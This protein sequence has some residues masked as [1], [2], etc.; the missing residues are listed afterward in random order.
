MSGHRSLL[1]AN[2]CADDAEHLVRLVKLVPDEL[3]D[4]VSWAPVVGIAYAGLMPT[5]R[6]WCDGR[7]R[8]ERFLGLS[9]FGNARDFINFCGDDEPYS[10]HVVFMCDE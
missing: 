8:K 4:F 6:C 3:T 1:D 5:T 9:F 10:M 7:R 2:S